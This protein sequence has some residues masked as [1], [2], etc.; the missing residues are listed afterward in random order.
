MRIQADGFEFDFPGALDAYVFDEQA[1][2]APRFHGLSHAMKAVDLVVEMPNDTLFIEIKDFHAPDDYNFKAATSDGEKTQRRQSVNHLMNVLVHKFR[3]TWLYRW[4][5]RP[6]GAPDK[7][8][9]Y[10]CLLTLDNG[11]LGVLNKELRQTLPI[12]MAGPRWQRELGVGCA[13]LN[14]QRWATTFPAWSLRR[15]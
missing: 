11:L 5:E 15:V 9:R 2:T 8:V 4:A 7:P 12:G 6:A 1:K 13:V 14:P 10:L 3:D